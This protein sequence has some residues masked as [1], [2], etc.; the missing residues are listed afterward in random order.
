MYEISE[1]AYDS[2]VENTKKFNRLKSVF[3][4][5][6]LP[7]LELKH[8]KQCHFYWNSKCDLGNDTLS[9]RA[10]IECPSFLEEKSVIPD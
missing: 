5:S 3:E 2:F 7:K 8:C 9:G 10:A 4:E 1:D 6:N